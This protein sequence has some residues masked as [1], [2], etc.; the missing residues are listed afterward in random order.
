MDIYH[1]KEVG[2][3]ISR[4]G[5]FFSALVLVGSFAFADEELKY[6]DGSPRW[7]YRNKPG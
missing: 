1:S 6:D 2:N 7:I 5:W 4:F 3:M